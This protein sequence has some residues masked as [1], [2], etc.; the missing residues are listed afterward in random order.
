MWYK[1]F[2]LYV[3]G[4]NRITF[5][6][7]VFIVSKVHVEKIALSEI[8]YTSSAKK[9]CAEILTVYDIAIDLKTIFFKIQIPQ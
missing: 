3:Q 6:D 9:S 2:F 4:C 5:P 1:L 7:H 8:R